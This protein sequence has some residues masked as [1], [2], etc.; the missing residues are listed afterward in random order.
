MEDCVFKNESQEGRQDYGKREKGNKNFFFAV[1]SE[2]RKHVFLP[3]I[4]RTCAVE[5]MKACYFLFKL[6][7][8]DEQAFYYSDKVWL[9]LKNATQIR[10]L[11]NIRM[12]QIRML[13][14]R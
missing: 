3:M 8:C 13:Q 12:T 7:S 6:I 14:P 4:S 2:S 10:S 11:F 9:F 1:N 5:T